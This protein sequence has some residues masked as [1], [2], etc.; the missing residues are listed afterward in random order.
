M[1]KKIFSI[2]GVI[3]IVTM[4]FGHIINSFN[5][6]IEGAEA[7]LNFN[8]ITDVFL[9]LLQVLVNLCLL[10][11]LILPIIYVIIFLPTLFVIELIK[12]RNNYINNLFEKNV[13]YTYLIGLPIVILILLSGKFY[14]YNIVGD[15]IFYTDYV[16]LL[17]SFIIFLFFMKDSKFKLKY[18]IFMI[19]SNKIIFFLIRLSYKF[20]LKFINIQIIILFAYII[21]NILISP[22]LYKYFKELSY[23]N[24][25]E[26]E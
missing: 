1:I 22:I 5:N 15:L 9:G 24:C 26:K 17:C 14:Y 19:I 8:S 23:K 16:I 4:G 2:L 10:I 13:L 20:L 18:W 12:N 7:V 11:P 6:I 3:I 25:F 21:M